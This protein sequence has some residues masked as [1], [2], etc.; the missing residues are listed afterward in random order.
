MQQ[1]RDCQSALIST[2]CFQLHIRCLHL[3]WDWYEDIHALS[4]FQLR[5]IQFLFQHLHSKFQLITE[6][7]LP[8]RIQCYVHGCHHPLLIYGPNDTGRFRVCWLIRI[9]SS[10]FGPASGRLPWPTCC[11][12]GMLFTNSNIMHHFLHFIAVIYLQIRIFHWSEKCICGYNLKYTSNSTS[13]R[14]CQLPYSYSA[15]SAI[16]R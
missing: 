5:I 13:G 2:S 4:G 8:G 16:Q 12:I 10:N 3:I 9:L 7:H 14:V 1:M 15:L 11:Y 6:P